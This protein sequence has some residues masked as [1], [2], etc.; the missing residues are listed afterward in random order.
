MNIPRVFKGHLIRLDISELG[1][2]NDFVEGEQRFAWMTN[3]DIFMVALTEEESVIAKLKYNNNIVQISRDA[4][5][6]QALR[7]GFLYNI[8]DFELY[9]DDIIQLLMIRY[10]QEIIGVGDNNSRL[11]P[12]DKI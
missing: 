9:P 12:L 7:Y 1:N 6:S 2:M 11:L 4:N 8:F 3:N 5:I 10:P